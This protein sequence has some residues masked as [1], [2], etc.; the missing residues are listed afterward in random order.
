VLQ[1]TASHT[2]F[3]GILADVLE[4]ILA[5]TEENWQE[6]AEALAELLRPLVER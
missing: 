2:D 5:M 4:E 1:N 6:K 3:A